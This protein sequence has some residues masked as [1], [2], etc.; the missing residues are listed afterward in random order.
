MNRL[1]FIL[2][3]SLAL[4]GCA[5]GGQAPSLSTATQPKVGTSEATES[6]TSTTQGSATR[7]TQSAT[8]C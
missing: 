3:A 5:G 7:A 4:A 2:I 1:L 8:D 6:A